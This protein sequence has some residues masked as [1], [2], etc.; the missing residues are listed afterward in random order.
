MRQFEIELRCE[1]YVC[2]MTVENVESLP[3]DIEIKKR[4]DDILIRVFYT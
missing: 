3:A 4:K 1:A 2:D